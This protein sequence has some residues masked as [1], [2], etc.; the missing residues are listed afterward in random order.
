MTGT[1]DCRTCGEKKPRDE[2][3]VNKRYKSGRD[4]K[5]KKCCAEATAAHRKNRPDLVRAA[6]ARRWRRH[7]KKREAS[8][9]RWRANNPE[10]ARALWRRGTRRWREKNPDAVKAYSKMHAAKH[11]AQYAERAALRRARIARASPS[12]VSGVHRSEIK[13]KHERAAELSRRDG[14]PYHVD[15]I[16]PIAGKGVR[17]LHVPWNLQVIP[18]S[19]N[20]RKWIHMDTEES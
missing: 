16:I 6:E 5:C 20:Q 1:S 7:R 2:F 10:R 8:V 9:K 19:E 14:Q 12:W 13:R 18:A 3:P 17:G 11:P 4:T 15:H